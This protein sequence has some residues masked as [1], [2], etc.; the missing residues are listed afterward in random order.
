[1]IQKVFI[2]AIYLQMIKK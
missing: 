1:M 2:I